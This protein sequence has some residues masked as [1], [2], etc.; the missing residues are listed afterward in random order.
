MM[1]I[2]DV[3]LAVANGKYVNPHDV[4]PCAKDGLRR[5]AEKLLMLSGRRY[6]DADAMKKER[7][8][9][10][11]AGLNEAIATA[12][13]EGMAYIVKSERIMTIVKALEVRQNARV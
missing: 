5:I 12:E 4:K 8:G 9:K 11:I 3:F 6:D 1:S 10:D 7:M 13:R 2:G